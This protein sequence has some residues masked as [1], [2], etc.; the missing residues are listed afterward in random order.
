MKNYNFQKIFKKIS[1]FFQKFYR[2]FGENLET[3]W[4]NLEI[5]ISRGFG[6]GAP[7]SSEFI[8][9]RVE[10]SKETLNFRIV[11]MEFLA[12]FHIF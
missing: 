10:K 5:C 7:G 6:G 12:F 2:I 4:E 1:Q 11:L 9:I 8:E 3:N